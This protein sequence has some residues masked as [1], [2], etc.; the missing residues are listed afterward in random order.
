MIS[1]QPLKHK[2]CHFGVF[3][4]TLLSSKLPALD[5]ATTAKIDSSL[6][7]VIEA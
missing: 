5:I 1:L 6:V 7:F 4:Y 3:R 2:A